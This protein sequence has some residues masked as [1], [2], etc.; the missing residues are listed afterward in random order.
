VQLILTQTTLLP[1]SPRAFSQWQRGS[2]PIQGIPRCLPWRDIRCGLLLDPPAG[3]CERRLGCCA[4]FLGRG[5]SN[6]SLI[7]TLKNERH[8]ATRFSHKTILLDHWKLPLAASLSRRYLMEKQV[9]SR[10]IDRKEMGRPGWPNAT[11]AVT[12]RKVTGYRL[13]GIHCFLLY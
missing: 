7:H 11:L 12:R 6:S 5:I 13:K 4:P 10:I 8:V 9:D 3:P 2:T 1:V